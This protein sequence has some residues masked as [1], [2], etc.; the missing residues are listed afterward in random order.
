VARKKF[1]MFSLSEKALFG[2]NFRRSLFGCLGKS[3]AGQS[4]YKSPWT[5]M[6][7][8]HLIVQ[9]FIVKSYP[10]C[11][12]SK[13]YSKLGG[14]GI[15]GVGGIWSKGTSISCRTVSIKSST[16]STRILDRFSGHITW[17]YLLLRSVEAMGKWTSNLEKERVMCQ[18]LANSMLETRYQALG[19]VY[20]L[21]AAL[22]NAGLESSKVMSYSEGICGMRCWT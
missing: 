22:S 14:V 8:L 2:S 5:S 9:P 18:F 10:K 3:C 15:G 6:V 17:V 13:V 11:S 21:A 12:T 1:F 7:G 4:K 20:G 19:L 16:E